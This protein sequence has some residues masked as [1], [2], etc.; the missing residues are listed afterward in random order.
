LLQ[1]ID[2]VVVV[3]IADVVV[4]VAG[5][6]GRHVDVLVLVVVVD[7]RCCCCYGSLRWI[8]LVIDFFGR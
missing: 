8:D 6:A 1:D 7:C 4:C 2:A 3:D 5:V